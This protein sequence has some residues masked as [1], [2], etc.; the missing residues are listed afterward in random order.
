[1]SA[2]DTP[3][4]PSRSRA[5]PRWLWVVLILSLAL[6][7]LVAGAAVGAFVLGRH[8][9]A[10]SSGGMAG[11]VVQFARQLPSERRSQI[12]AEVAEQRKAIRPLWRETGRLRR[13]LAALLAADPFDGAAF[14]ET[15]RRMLEAE[16]RARAAGQALVSAIATRLSAEE[17][18]ALLAKG[19]GSRHGGRHMRGA[20]PTL[21]DDAPAEEPRR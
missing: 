14:A 13:Q 3:T 16:M 18:R 12:W 6:N 8:T 7:L 1:V 2:S 10:W 4:L 17:R 9:M 19:F 15:Q 20:R 11:N 5:A 21:D